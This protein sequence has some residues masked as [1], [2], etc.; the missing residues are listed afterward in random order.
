[1]PS[2]KLIIHSVDIKTNSA[3]ISLSD[4][5]N[6]IFI[7]KNIIIKINDDKTID[8]NHLLNIIKTYVLSR[9]L[10]ELKKIEKDII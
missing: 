8:K 10:N 1:M 3:I 2:V 7:N 6:D 9:R 5:K 4:N